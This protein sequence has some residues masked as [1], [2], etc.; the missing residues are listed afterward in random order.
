MTTG[1]TLRLRAAMK[2]LS[3][4][5]RPLDTV[6]TATGEPAQAITQRSD[7]CAVPRAGVVAEA[8]VALVVA[9]AL[10]EKTGGDT[11]AEVRRNLEGYRAGL[12][13]TWEQR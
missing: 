10:L 9:D 12:R 11:L 8:V 5:T 3:S 1:E 7:V 13:P 2:P 4:L 6:D